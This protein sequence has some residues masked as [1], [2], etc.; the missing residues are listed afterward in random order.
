MKNLIKTIRFYLIFLL[1]F[2]LSVGPAILAA[3]DGISVDKGAAAAN[4]ATLDT[5]RNGVPVVNIVN[6][7]A[8]GLSHNKFTNYNVDKK[9]LVLNNSKV[10]GQSKLAG[11]IYAN[12]NLKNN[13]STILNE[14]TSTNKSVLKGYTEVFGNR[15][16]V[17]VANPNGITCNGCG[18]IN[19]PK[20]TLTTGRPIFNGS[21]FSGFDVDKGRVLIEGLGLNTNADY[22]DII[23]RVAEI[24]AQ[25]YAD[26]E[27]N[28]ITGRNVYDYN[29]GKITPKAEAKDKPEF[30]IDGSLLGSI[31][32]GVINFVSTEKGVGVNLGGDVTSMGRLS[33]SSEGD[34]KYKRIESAGKI[35]VKALGSVVQKSEAKAAGSIDLTAGD[36]IELKGVLASNSN[37]NIYGKKEIKS[38]CTITTSSE[39]SIKL[40]SDGTIEYET[41]ESSK[42]INI[43]SKDGAIVQSKKSL[44]NGTLNIT[45]KSLSLS[46]SIQS[47]EDMNF[48]GKDITLIGEL[49]SLQNMNIT[50]ESLNSKEAEIYTGVFGDESYKGDLNIILSKNAEYKK[51][52]AGGRIKIEAGD[53]TQV[54]SLLSADTFEVIGKD[55]TLNGTTQSEK[56][57]ILNG[58]NINLND[59]VQSLNNLNI[60][61]RGVVTNSGNLYAGVFNNSLYQGNL[62][63]TAD[64]DISLN[65]KIQANGTFYIKSSSNIHQG[66][67]SSLESL[68]NLTISGENLNCSGIIKSISNVSLNSSGLIDI[69]GSV[70]AGLYENDTYKG[71]IT[72]KGNEIEYQ[73]LIANGDISI[74]GK[75]I[76]QKESGAAYA[77]NEI[78]FT[79][80][81]TV[82]R[83]GY[84]LGL[85]G[86]NITSDYFTNY[87]NLWAGVFNG[88]KLD[89]SASINVNSKKIENSGE[90]IAGRNI[91]ITSSGYNTI[92]NY[93]YFGA[94][95]DIN[96]KF[97]SLGINS[98]SEF[99]S[100]NT[101]KFDTNN[102]FTFN[103]YGKFYAD[104]LFKLSS[105]GSIANNHTDL[106]MNGAIELNGSSFTNNGTIT[107]NKLVKV[108][109]PESIENYGTITSAGSIDFF[110]GATFANYANGKII[111]GLGETK[112]VADSN[113]YNQG[114]LT[115]A[116]DLNLRAGNDFYNHVN[117]QIVSGGNLK[118]VSSGS[119]MNLSGNL[120]FSNGD[121]LL[122]A[123]NHI[124]NNQSDILS[125]GSITLQGL[126]GTKNNRI[127]NYVGTIEADGDM[128]INTN[129][130]DNIGE[131]Y[132]LGNEWYTIQNTKYG[133][134]W[135]HAVVEENKAI[136]NFSTRPAYINSNGNL[137]INA[138][139]THNYGSQIYGGN[140]NISGGTLENITTIKSIY[141][142]NHQLYGFL[143]NDSHCTRH[144][145]GKCKNWRY[146][147]R[148]SIGS[149]QPGYVSYSSK[150]PGTIQAG[151]YLGINVS[152]NVSNGITQGSNAKTLSTKSASTS[153]NTATIDN[154]KK[155]GMVDTSELATS[156]L[157]GIL[158]KG[159]NGLFKVNTDSSKKVSVTKQGTPKLNYIIETN[160][161]YIDLS[162]FYGS[163]YFMGK[164]GFNPEEDTKILGD[165]YFE[166]K[167]VNKAI[168]EST[169][170]K[171]LND[172]IKSDTDQMKYLIDNG[173][174]AQKDLQLSVGVTLS[175]EIINQLNEP[176]VWFV[177]KEINGMLAIV[178]EVYMPESYTDRLSFAQ[179]T[180]TADDVNI[181]A[182]TVENAGKISSN[183]SLSIDATSITNETSQG[184][185]QSEIVGKNVSLMSKEEIINLGSKIFGEESLFLKAEGNIVNET[186]VSRATVGAS[187]FS[188]LDSKASIGSGGFLSVDAGKNFL[189]KA[190]KVSAAGDASITAG[191]NINFETIAL[192]NKSVT[193]N[194][195]V[196][197]TKNYGSSLQVGGSLKMDSK[198]DI[199]VI[200]SSVDVAGDA[201]VTTG[202]DLNIL[203]AQDS[204]YSKTVTT[205]KHTFSKKTTTT[206]VSN[207]TNVESVFNIGGKLDT[208]S[209][210]DVKVVGSEVGA[211]EIDIK[212]K[213]DVNILAGYNTSFSESKTVKSGLFSGGSL[214][215]K[216]LDIEGK[217]DKT[218]VGSKVSA[219]TIS[220]KTG[221]DIVFEGAEVVADKMKTDSGKDT[222]VTAAEEEHYSYSVHEKTTVG[223][224]DFAKSLSRPDK[225][226][227][228]KDGRASVKVSEAKYDKTK[229]KNSQTTQKGSDLKIGEE[230]WDAVSEK[231]IVIKGSDVASTGDITLEAKENVEI[232]YAEEKTKSQ[233][234]EIHGKAELSVGVSHQASN[235]YNAAKSLK[236][237]T[238][239]LK[240]T[241]EAY[242][243]YKDDL[244]TAKSNYK[245]GLISK[246]DYDDMKED[247]AF[248]IASIGMLAS[249]VEAKTLKLNQEVVG[250]SKTSGTYGFTGDV[251]LD[252]D[253]LIQKTE[254][255]IIKAKGSNLSAKNITIKAGKTASITGSDI[256]ASEDI[257][258]EA[259]DVAIAA[260]RN[261]ASF[262]S[263]TQHAN[264]QV[265]YSTASTTQ[266]FSFDASQSKNKNA[267]YTNSHIGGK[268]ITIKS[269]KDTTVEGGVVKATEDVD[270]D[271]GGD[272]KVV[273]LQDSSKSKSMSI[274]GGSSGVNAG[275]SRGNRKE[276]LEQSGIYAG[277]NFKGD[278]KGNTHLKGAVLS[279]DKENGV[280]LKTKTL[281][282]E[283]ISNQG[284]YS[285]VGAGVAMKGD[286][287]TFNTVAP[288]KASVGS[289]TKSAISSGTITT[290]SNISGL[291][292]DTSKTNGEMREID[293][294]L[295]AARQEVTGL[296]GQLGFK[297]IGDYAMSKE[298][299]GDKS[300]A[301]G[302][303][304]KT[305]AHAAMGGAQAFIGG[306][307]VLSG[308]AAAG[309]REMLSGLT[310][311]ASDNIQKIVSTTIGGVSGSLAGGDAATGAAAA[312]AGETYNRQLHQKEID[313]LKDEKVIKEYAE[314]KGITPE[315]AEKQLTKAGV[316]MVDGTWNKKFGDDAT[317]EEASQ[318]LLA[319]DNEA[320][321]EYDKAVYNDRYNSVETLDYQ[322][323]KFLEKNLDD[324]TPL[325]KDVG[326]V[327]KALGFVSGTFNGFFGSKTQEEEIMEEK[328]PYVKNLY[329]LSGESYKY[330]K[331]NGL[332]TAEGTKN[333]VNG[334]GNLP[335]DMSTPEAIKGYKDMGEG[336][337]SVAG[338]TVVISTI[339]LTGGA[340]TAGLISGV[341]YGVVAAAPTVMSLGT[342]ASNTAISLGTVASNYVA[343]NSDKIYN[344]TTKAAEIT[345]A[346]IVKGPTKTLNGHIA[347]LT[348][349]IIQEINEPY[350]VP[351]TKKYIKCLINNKSKKTIK[352]N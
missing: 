349:E 258:I 229:A 183:E 214:Y 344:I 249:S 208:T 256:N 264:Y 98:N 138:G 34:V 304:K 84:V 324:R 114:S 333:I 136:S 154:I 59:E 296:A 3:S 152:S 310:K 328:S 261:S 104:S 284:S 16:N 157:D 37:I 50:G 209:N 109:V 87:G 45:G 86:I 238:K 263:E 293:K 320:F 127:K 108:N 198:Q 94:Y 336:I 193:S 44:A 212:A 266:D 24:N 243:K 21:S 215:S 52:V 204:Y 160:V 313:I 190:A 70:Y 29:T 57:I 168:F 331:V 132:A 25:I 227:T 186:T 267:S 64:N 334:V 42:D 189:N 33:I 110:T 280:N 1:I 139:T 253:A 311:D 199:N 35:D 49:Q 65:G 151:N 140:V 100:N 317:F 297:A 126:N 20:V 165:S 99:H 177:E 4:Q 164:T 278:V 352:D 144:R 28:I 254:S 329:E 341:T 205:K 270:L 323:T 306:G 36:A 170:K 314:E 92:N 295:V 233:K 46:G 286:A 153:Y 90:V 275:I 32:A 234:E 97:S 63:I 196:D 112:I 237:T 348:Q 124:E 185:V 325:Q 173:L 246:E 187:I 72:L 38:P 223:L 201:K 102:N 181:T 135:S 288:G 96:L 5:A 145:F 335:S 241:K 119:L 133:Y 178:P 55:I 342:T 236:E 248:Y 51:I 118:T 179:S 239:K 171:F 346:L 202:G 149:W 121:M 23:T 285:S 290:G 217:G 116:G 319:Q 40:N 30:S 192:R 150:N 289:I 39:G 231:N 244:S 89:D 107:S 271:V 265:K 351:E 78:N 69:M 226:V 73:K 188:S 184:A 315:E 31:Y 221:E 117:G 307:N 148:S 294:D 339:G 82:N 174:K 172:D 13:A 19:T 277:G 156:Y 159:E 203:A 259:E 125:L 83:D 9:G 22:F 161:E 301:D 240:E 194:R 80:N 283:D 232:T 292:R 326:G 318:Y 91:N 175:K 56:D 2:D 58:N 303:T 302:G 180:I 345:E 268:N 105:T 210:K 300:W 137:T 200:G 95:N 272:L 130:L 131:D 260:A 197:E 155:T 43:T 235:V 225:M 62:F 255:E 220:I 230:G 330:G 26:K 206:I 48:S 128:T 321:R 347:F 11:Q 79:G 279:S 299:K 81:T 308:A 146:T 61:S 101:L 74:T 251:T 167:L 322:N 224:G 142:P 88:E 182:D 298:M 41:I 134:T 281:T 68:N 113:F 287:A 85:K 53:I 158:K 120:I 54:E 143:Y 12:T 162:K 276:V 216:Q 282:Y 47:V 291:S 191:E 343:V 8:N 76:T 350:Y 327:T 247:E 122:E 67:E 207:S 129:Y 123:G 169:G 242:S 213:G 337:K 245:K 316:A 147:V 305:L 228:L 262:S 60:T 103:N 6:P 166:T 77:K 10:S 75:S 15:A 66:S 257:G 195:T 338:K 163:D 93:G 17:I 14:V 332:K 250:L 222:I 71:N 312:Y 7:N 252:V 115:G 18:F 106:N 211:T 274:G 111:G 176:I 219:K 309:S 218:A 141:I 273:S 27:L 340:A 269:T